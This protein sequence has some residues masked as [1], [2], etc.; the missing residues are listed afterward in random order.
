MTQEGIFKIIGHIT[1]FYATLDFFVTRFIFESVTEEYKSKNKPMTDFI[2]LGQ[3]LDLIS[4]LQDIDVKSA[5]ALK[6]AKLSMDEAKAVAKE[7]NRFIHDLWKFDPRDL[8]N[9]QITRMSQIN[10][11]TWKYDFKVSDAYTEQDLY[12]LLGRIGH[13]Q[14]IFG[15]L[16]PK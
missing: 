6:Q 14:K 3:K 1:I 16:V 15:D 2:T 11:K 9:G 12:G 7:R 10:L 8:E 4:N 13:L 5:D